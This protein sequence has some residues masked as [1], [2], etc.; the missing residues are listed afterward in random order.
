MT[1]RMPLRTA[2]PP[3]E[4]KPT[5]LATVSVWP[6]QHQGQHAAD[7]RRRQGVEDLQ[8]DP[9]RREQHHTARRTCRPATPPPG[10]RSAASPAAGSRTGRRTRR[11]SPPAVGT[12]SSH[13]LLDLGDRRWPGRGPATLQRM[14][15]R[16]RTFSRLTAF[17][18]AAPSPMS[19]TSPQPH[20]AAAVRQVDPQLARASRSRCGTARPAARPGRTAA[21]LRAPATRP[22]P[23][24]AVCTNSATYARLTP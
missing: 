13:A 3:S 22:R 12:R 20:L 14:T 2:M 18:P 24:S 6:R 19:A 1:S 9:H 11:S 4:M 15:I 8:H 5:R 23:C 7:E 10:R 17:G 16:R 21:A